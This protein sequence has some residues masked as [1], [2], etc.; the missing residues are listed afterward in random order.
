MR[1]RAPIYR[2]VHDLTKKVRSMGP[3]A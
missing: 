2:Q 3:G 1:D